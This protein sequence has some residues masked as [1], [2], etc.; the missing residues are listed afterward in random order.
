MDQNFSTAV[1]CLV[2]EAICDAEVLLGVLLWLIVQL[3]VEVLEVAIALRI[4]LASYIEDVSHTCLNQL[5]CLE[6]TLEWTHVD[7]LIH[8]KETDVSDCLLAVDIA[9]TEVDVRE[10]PASHLLLISCVRLT[11]IILAKTGF[12]FVDRCTTEPRIALNLLELR[13]TD[14]PRLLAVTLHARL[15]VLVLVVPF[16]LHIVLVLIHASLCYLFLVHL[17]SFKTFLVSLSKNEIFLL[18]FL[19]ITFPI[20][21]MLCGSC[22]I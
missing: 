14:S 16:L 8:L 22:Q 10:A 18:I 1:E 11:V 3:Q 12:L 15:I 9:G 5:T 21:M 4:R 17:L 7:A 6:G 13:D 2:Y 20:L 19:E